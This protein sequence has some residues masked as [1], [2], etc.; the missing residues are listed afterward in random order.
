M[1]GDQVLDG[2]LIPNQTPAYHAPTG[3]ISIVDAKLGF[4]HRMALL[5]LDHAMK[6]LPQHKV[7]I[8]GL[9]NSGHVS[10]VGTYSEYCAARGYVSIHMVNVVGHPPLVAPHGACD[11][12]FSTNPI[13]MAMPVGGHAQPMLDMATSTVAFGKVRVASNKGEKMPPGCLVDKEGLPTTDPNPMAERHD[14]ALSAF[15]EHKGSGLGIFVELMAG[16]L[17]STDTVAT[18]E[19]LPHGVITREIL[20]PGEPEINNRAHRQEF[21]IPVDQETIHQ[22]IE[23]GAHFN[24][25]KDKL[26]GLLNQVS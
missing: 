19:N 12:G 23:T 7:A 17:A 15:G 21:G 24:L 11:G 4:G 5:G 3:A 18:K 26:S 10:R 20:M 25:D 13:S 1:Y 22:L 16:A 2:N 6:T 9:R 14:G 8:L